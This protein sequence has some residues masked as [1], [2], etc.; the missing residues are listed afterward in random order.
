MLSKRRM[1][2]LLEEQADQ[3]TKNADQSTEMLQSKLELWHYMDSCMKIKN[4]KNV[5]RV[6]YKNQLKQLYHTFLCASEVEFGL[7]FMDKA[8]RPIALR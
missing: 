5:F 4:I 1:L 7:R 8:I 6:C 3:S 2:C